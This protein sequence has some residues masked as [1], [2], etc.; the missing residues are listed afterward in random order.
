[1]EHHGRDIGFPRVYNEDMIDDRSGTCVPPGAL[2]K[3][4]E[5]PEPVC[6]C[7]F[8]DGKHAAGCPCAVPGVDVPH[9]VTGTSVAQS[10]DYLAVPMNDEQR[11]EAHR[12]FITQGQARRPEPEKVEI[13]QTIVPSSGAKL[14]CTDCGT[15]SWHTLILRRKAG[16]IEG[17]CKQTDGSGCYPMASRR[18]CQ[19]SYP[20]N[21]DCPQL[22]EYCVAVGKERRGERQVCRD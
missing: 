5:L 17:L 3:S 1:M 6:S 2:N 9:F 18:N 13:I 8:I 14:V 11:A 21:V 10:S 22:A 20:N 15:Q 4:I 12:V 16:L 7:G 19:Y